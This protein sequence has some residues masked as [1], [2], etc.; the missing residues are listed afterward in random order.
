[1]RAL[2]TQYIPRQYTWCKQCMNVKTS[3]VKSLSFRGH[4]SGALFHQGTFIFQRWSGWKQQFSLWC[5]R[6]IDLPV[7]HLHINGLNVFAQNRYTKNRNMP[8]LLQLIQ[9]NICISLNLWMCML[10]ITSVCFGM[11]SKCRRLI[12]IKY[13]ICIIFMSWIHLVW[14]RM[15][16]F[17]MV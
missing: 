6:L 8:F 10:K 3:S 15:T 11:I 16:W 14:F 9:Y 17:N 2:Q 5:R 7:F 4:L 1:M 13:H 12:S